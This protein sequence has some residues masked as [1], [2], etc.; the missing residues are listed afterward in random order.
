MKKYR[1]GVVGGGAI[2]QACHIPGYAAAPNC[3]LVAI[4]DPEKKCLKM[5]RE[6]GF[7]FKNE[8]SDYKEMLA[9]EKLDIVSVCVP[10]KFHAEVAIAAMNAGADLLLEKPIAM[11]MKEAEAISK[12]AGKLKRRVMMGFS[13]RFN[14]LNIAAK[15][16]VDE[17]KIGKPYM[18]R[19]RFAHTGP[20]PGWAKTDWFYKPELAGGGALM[21]MAVHAFDI[22]QWLISPNVESVYAQVATLRKDIPVDDNVVAVVEFKGKCMGYVE[23]GW[24]SPAGF[25][26]IEIMGD[27]GVIFCNYG[28]GKATMLSGKISPDGT[29]KIVEKVLVEKVTSSAW[30]NELKYFTGHLSVKSNFNP[31]VETGVDTMRLVVAAYESS[32]KGKKINIK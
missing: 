2:A 26:G 11:N 30:V 15:K 4:A 1:I 14:E 31:G 12:T 22:I 6:K 8:Y 17:G 13:H 32:K 16:A 28:Q 5:V 25:I 27:N 9:K 20:I 10:N 23:C 7:K 19:V 18:I 3:E 24:T 29:S 21:D